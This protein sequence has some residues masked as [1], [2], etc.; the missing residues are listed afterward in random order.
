MIYKTESLYEIFVK[1]AS[2]FGYQFSGIDDINEFQYRETEL[3]WDLLIKS[4]IYTLEKYF[5]YDEGLYYVTHCYYDYE[6]Q[7]IDYHADNDDEE[8]DTKKMLFDRYYN[9]FTNLIN[10]MI[11]DYC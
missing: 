8:T 9:E 7:M 10:K 6:A 5:I 3:L 1:V 2:R 4:P 11:E